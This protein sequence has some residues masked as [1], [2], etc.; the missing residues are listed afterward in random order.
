MV[1]TFIDCIKIFFD[2]KMKKAASFCGFLHYVNI[3]VCVKEEKTIR[4]LLLNEV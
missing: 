4:P 2:K 3:A 1:G